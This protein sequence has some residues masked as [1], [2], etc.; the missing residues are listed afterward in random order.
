MRHAWEVKVSDRMR[1]LLCDTWAARKRPVWIPEILGT[2]D[3]QEDLTE[4]FSNSRHLEELYKHQSEDKK[5]Q[6]RKFHKARQKIKEK[7]AAMSGLLPNDLQLMSNVAGGLDRC[8]LYEAGLEAAH[9]RAKSS[10]AVTGFPPF[11]SGSE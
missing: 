10:Q 3:E 7:A 2:D 5:G 9:L 1:D 11:C 4:R 8:W 6:Y